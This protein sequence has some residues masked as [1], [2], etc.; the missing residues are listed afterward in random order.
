MIKELAPWGSVL[1]GGPRQ[2][3]FSE[4]AQ[5][6]E[7]KIS[8]FLQFDPGR[9]GARDA[10]DRPGN[11]VPAQSEGSL[12]GVPIAVKDNIAVEGFQFSCG[13][14]VL[15]GLTA[16]Y[17]ATC[18]AKLCNAGARVVGKT[19]LDEF[20]M[21]SSCDNSA[22]AV[23]NNPYDLARVPGGS[24]GGSAAAVAAGIVPLAVGTDTGGSVRQPASFCGILGL[25]PT[26]GAV[27]RYGL[28]AYA[29]SLEC[30]G[31]LARSVGVLEAG[32]EAMRGIDPMDHTS[33]DSPESAKGP[34]AP[35]SVA[36]LSGLSRLAPEV[37]KAQAKALEILKAKGYAVR[38]VGIKSLDYV[39][40]A[41]YTIATA[42]AS[43]NLARY[44]GI[45]Y[46]RRT[47]WAE[48]PEELIKKSRSEG[49]G[50][51]VKL[52][53]LL[54][55][56]VLR[57]GF[58]SR[59]YVRAQ[60]LRTLIRNELYAAF[61]SSD[62]VLMPVFPTLAFPHGDSGMDDYQQRMADNFTCTANLAGLPALSVPTGLESG[63]P[64]GV[65]LMARP[66]READLFAAARDIL[67][68]VAIDPPA[69]FSEGFLK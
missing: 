11:A 51:E 50:N 44:T 38:E 5:G 42:E 47:E 18:V 4:Y 31:L 13:S 56:Y 36:I 27:S 53:V 41:Y 24:S 69:G 55:T 67:G 68:E 48:N 17:T 6:W 40:A 59:Y 46:G 8:S 33:L 52:R 28:A 49:F 66:F 34:G 3:A 12:A 64:A 63:L 7:A 43:A 54:G 20:G 10:K 1:D 32:F 65:Q 16:P 2:K 45:S 61:E 9:Q 29:S 39:L 23:T 30:A 62:L 26:Y 22:Y 25:K 35:K 58:Q 57:S 14:K 37:E 19:N 60:K 21:G 15:E